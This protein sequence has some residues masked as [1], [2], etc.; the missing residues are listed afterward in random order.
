M[1]HLIDHKV[2]LPGVSVLERLVSS[3]REQGFSQMP[4]RVHVE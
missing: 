2:L 3:V 1:A 4:R